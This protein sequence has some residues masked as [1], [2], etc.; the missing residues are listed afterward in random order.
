[1]ITVVCFA[2]VVTVVDAMSAAVTAVTVPG[3]FVAATA[4]FVPT[5]G[6]DAVV[7]E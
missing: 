2:A 5:F 1:M 3:P 7:D 4:D 6:S